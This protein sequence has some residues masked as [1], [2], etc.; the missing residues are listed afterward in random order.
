MIESFLEERVH[1]VCVILPFRTRLGAT[2]DSRL[3]LYVYCQADVDWF[4][5]RQSITIR[6]VQVEDSEDLTAQ[7]PD[8]SRHFARVDA[9]TTRF[10]FEDDPI[11]LP[12]LTTD[13]RELADFV[14]R[15]LFGV[16]KQAKA[17]CHHI[18][19]SLRRRTRSLRGVSELLSPPLALLLTGASGT[20]SYGV[21]ESVWVLESSERERASRGKLNT[22]P[23]FLR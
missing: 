8:W 3:E 9:V 21:V 22:I 1:W 14:S 5:F 16:E 13:S 4:G 17:V 10:C 2:E 20:G 19:A 15:T 23:P 6:R 11:I 18:Q 12:S 7:A